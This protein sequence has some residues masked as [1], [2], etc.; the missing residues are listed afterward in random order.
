MLSAEFLIKYRKYRENLLLRCSKAAGGSGGC[1]ERRSFAKPIESSA[2]KKRAFDTSCPHSAY[3]CI[4]SWLTLVFHP[5]YVYRRPSPPVAHA[6][7]QSCSNSLRPW[8]QS[9]RNPDQRVEYRILFI[10]QLALA[11]EFLFLF[12]CAFFFL[13]PLSFKG[14][15]PPVVAQRWI[16]R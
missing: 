4:S 9:M 12:T 8:D 16:A 10:S 11:N 15:K 1:L 2:L 3:S 7:M 6:V 5:R 13:T 14:H